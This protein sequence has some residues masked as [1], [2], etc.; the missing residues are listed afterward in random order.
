[1]KFYK[2]A[3]ILFTVLAVGAAASVSRAVTLDLGTVWD[4]DNLPAEVLGYEAGIHGPEAAIADAINLFAGTDFEE[5]DILKTNKDDITTN[6]F[7]QIVIG[8]G[9]DYLAIQYDGPE[10]GIVV[11]A[12][13]G[14]DALVPFLSTNIWGG[15]GQYGV[16]HIAVTGPGETVPDGGS[17]VVLMG[18]GLVTLGF[19]RRKLQA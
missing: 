15:E 1:M 16:S 8:P 13:N 10:G 5:G 14:M 2:L 4:K 11:I 17:M 9:Y 18:L 3:K 19:F 7:G 12:L 6:L